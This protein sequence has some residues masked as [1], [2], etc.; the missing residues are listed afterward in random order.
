MT[1]SLVEALSALAADVGSES[2]LYEAAVERIVDAAAHYDWVGIYVVE[3]DRLSLA[4]W[5]GPQPT[6]HVSIPLDQGICGFAATAGETVVVDD[7][8]ADPRYLACF[9][10][11]RSEIVVPILAGGEVVA[12]IDIDSDTRGAFGPRDREVLEAAANA[13]GERV[14]ELRSLD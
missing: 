13:I 10:G 14:A 4:A 11:T 1:V 12:E 7:V 3:G 6:E 5:R 2:E 8:N 9:L